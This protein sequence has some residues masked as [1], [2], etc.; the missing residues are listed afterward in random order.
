MSDRGGPTQKDLDQLVELNNQFDQQL[1]DLGKS[2]KSSTAK[3]QSEKRFSWKKVLLTLVLLMASLI[4]P[5]IVLV[6]TSVFMYLDYGFNGWLA[7]LA[8]IGATVGLLLVCG[9]VISFMYRKSL[10]IHRYLVRGVLILVTAYT[11]YGVLYYSSLNTKT[12]QINSYYR[13]LHPIVRVALTTITLADSDLLVTDI[14][15]QPEDYAQMGLPKNQQSLHYVQP[16]GY[17][18]AVDLRTRGRS[19]WKNGLTRLAICAVGLQSIRH[20]GT[21]DHL[22]VYLP[23]NE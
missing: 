12:D 3:A 20:V 21:A 2:S 8:G 7:L 16:N 18:H 9:L 1:A 15:R 4:I 13:S 17:I 14:K 22:H 19:E 5:F 23:L 10:G 6:R 11:L